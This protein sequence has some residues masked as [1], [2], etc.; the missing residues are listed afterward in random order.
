MAARA[1]VSKVPIRRQYTETDRWRAYNH[2]ISTGKFTK[3]TAKACFIS[4]S[5]VRAWVAKW[6]A[7][8]IPNQPSPEELGEDIQTAAGDLQQMETLKA[9]AMKR[10]AEVIPKTNSADQLVRVIKDLSERID[11]ANGLHDVPS[12]LNVNLRLAEAQVAGERLVDLVRSTLASANERSEV[13]IDA[14]TEPLQ[15]AASTS[16]D[17]G[18]TDG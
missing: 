7:G 5:T 4:V 14:D 15:L 1:R 6:E 13:I 17:G 16:E 9:L 12:T 11:R 8:D 2:W 18:T 3:T 10:L